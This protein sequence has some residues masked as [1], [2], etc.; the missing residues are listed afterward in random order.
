MSQIVLTEGAA[1][2]TPSSN[3]L[4]VYV[5]SDKLLY[6]KDDAGNEFLLGG[7]SAPQYG[8]MGCQGGVA[9]ESTV[10]ATP[11]KIA[12]WNTNGAYNGVVPDQATG[13]DLTIGTAGV[14]HIF[15]SVT[16]VGT[17]SKTMRFEIYKNGSATG[18]AIEIKADAAADNGAASIG[19]YLSCAATDTIELYQ[20][21]T[22]G[23]TAC[24]ISEGVLM[25]HRVG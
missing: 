13:D 12:A 15:A 18:Y 22:D 10:D 24:T 14:Y 8:V 25:A 6:G 4:T 2:G 23:G 16:F 1:P 21:S 20:S 7:A 3:K 19:C 11:R 17:A 9:A 5:K